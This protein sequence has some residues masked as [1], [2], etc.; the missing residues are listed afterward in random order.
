MNDGKTK[1]PD[2]EDVNATPPLWV[3]GWLAVGVF[4]RASERVSSAES[5]D[6]GCSSTV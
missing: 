5:A 6:K 2:E 1:N 4:S 3:Q